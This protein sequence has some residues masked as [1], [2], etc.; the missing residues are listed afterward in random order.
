MTS[1]S[2]SSL[3]IVFEE[4]NVIFEEQKCRLLVTENDLLLSYYG[5][6]STDSTSIAIHLQHR[7]LLGLKSLS[8]PDQNDAGRSDD[9]DSELLM[10]RSYHSVIFY[11]YPYRSHNYS[12]WS[13]FFSSKED[14]R[15]RKEICLRF[16][17]FNDSRLKEFV[18]H[19]TVDISKSVTQGNE[20]QSSSNGR[21]LIFLNPASGQGKSLSLW[22]STIQPMIHEAEI[23]FDLVS[24]EYPGH[25]IDL[26]L[27][28]SKHIQGEQL[29]RSQKAKVKVLPLSVE[30]YST[31]VTIGGDGTYSEVINGLLGRE[32]DGKLL[33]ERIPVIPL[34]TGSGNALNRSILFTNKE[35]SSLLNAVFNLIRGK[36]FPKDL[37]KIY[38]YEKGKA[39]NTSFSS[40]EDEL[41][42]KTAYSFLMLSYGIVADLDINSEH[43]HFLGELRFCLYGIFYTLQRRCYSGRL[44]MKLVSDS[45]SF[46]PLA[47]S[48]DKVKD[49][50]VFD[51]SL[52]NSSNRDQGQWLT[53]QSDKFSFITVIHTAHLSDS[54][55]F[56]PGKRF[57][58]NIL[59]V[60]IAENVTRLQMFEILIRS[61]NGTHFNVKGVS[62]FHC[63]EYQLEPFLK[64]EKSS[65]NKVQ[66]KKEFSNGLIYSIDG[67]RFDA[68]PVK[69]MILPNASRI[70]LLE[71]N[72]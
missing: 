70:L 6:S 2:S 51:S 43:L 54:V 8:V 10:N 3:N 38:F 40:K 22:K 19:F 25:V 17:E 53:I 33:L 27:S 49:I 32:K 21:F 20:S 12:W 45:S 69:G 71:C 68:L 29:I 56:A 18:S 62:V 41:N 39:T 64:E 42:R 35:S 60:I 14:Q 52:D 55:Y 28:G 34:P 57:N 13:S 24:T 1:T 61:D 66:E 23:P 26:L 9:Q 36:P 50:I 11:Y 65:G 7:D 59:T 67:E 37:S 47:T 46:L 44:S 31:I 72:N 63:T 4:N 58:D 15:Y 48:L 30:K 16:P 5:K